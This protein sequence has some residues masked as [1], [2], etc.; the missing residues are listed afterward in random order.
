MEDSEL[1]IL[2]KLSMDELK[3]ELK[4]YPAEERIEKLKKVEEARK[5]EEEERKELK[6]ETLKEL[7]L[8]ERFEE[9]PPQEETPRREAAEERTL[10][11]EVSGTETVGTEGTDYGQG[12]YRIVGLYN[13]L[14]GIV[15]AE[16][17]SYDSVGRAEEIYEEI[18][19]HE[20]YQ[21]QEDIKDIAF[22]TRRLRKELMGDYMSQMYQD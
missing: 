3:E 4:K 18:I 7:S 20:N 14:R 19:Q 16:D 15:E 5:K 9:E 10:E 17:R 11:E 13:E 21:P 12:L 2:L 6:E 1:E 22:G 8:E